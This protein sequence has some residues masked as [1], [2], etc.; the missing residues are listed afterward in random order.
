M[1][2]HFCKFRVALILVIIVIAVSCK[3]ESD[4]YK[5]GFS[6]TINDH[7]YNID[8]L[9][10][11]Q[12]LSIPGNI[13]YNSY[14]SGESK[15][16]KY[17]IRF[18]C[19]NDN[20]TSILGNHIVS[21]LPQWPNPQQTVE[22]VLVTINDPADPNNA[23]FYQAQDDFTVNITYLNGDRIKGNFSGH[24]SGG[25]PVGGAFSPVAFLDIRTSMFSGKFDIKF[26]GF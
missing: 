10:F 17:T 3:K 11:S 2:M 4:S 14:F 13:L 6:F 21:S 26:I 5:P 15:D 9:R 25:V 22:D 24:L 18:T 20:D 7:N 16:G 8:T 12:M 1:L 23:W 19:K